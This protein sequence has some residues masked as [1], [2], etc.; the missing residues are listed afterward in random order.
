MTIICGASPTGITCSTESSTVSMMATASSDGIVTTN[1]VPSEVPVSHP[2]LERNIV[3][4]TVSAA[5]PA[6]SPPF[7]NAPMSTTEIVRPVV[8]ATYK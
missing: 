4:R 7:E 5:R 8:L 6:D 3:F 2:T 1:L